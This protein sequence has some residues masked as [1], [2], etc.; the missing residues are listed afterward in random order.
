MYVLS[1]QSRVNKMDR[2]H[3]SHLLGRE[4]VH[5]LL[6]QDAVALTQPFPYLTDSPVRLLLS[7]AENPVDEGFEVGRSAC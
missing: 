6:T 2:P 4:R 1:H 7:Y 3:P 5:Q